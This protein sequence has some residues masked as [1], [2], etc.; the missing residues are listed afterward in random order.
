MGIF[1]IGI[2]RTLEPLRPLYVSTVDNGNL[3]GYLIALLQALDDLI[4][5]P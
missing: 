2:I 3:V 4:K 5:R 1:I